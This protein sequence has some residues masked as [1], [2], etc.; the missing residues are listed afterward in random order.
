MYWRGETFY[1][2]NEIYEGPTEKRTV[3]LGTRN[4][5][6]LQAYLARNPGKRVFFVVEKSRVEKLKTL[7]ADGPRRT[8]KVLNDTNNKFLLACAQL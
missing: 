3:F 1:S 6:D 4:A 7:L 5:E 8:L 2:Q